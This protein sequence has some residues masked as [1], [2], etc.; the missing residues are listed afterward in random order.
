MPAA[1]PAAENSFARSGSQ[2]DNEHKPKIKNCKEAKDPE[3]EESSPKGTQVM[4]VI[5]ED[6]DGPHIPAGQIT[7]SIVSRHKK[8]TIDKKTGWLSTNAMFNRDEPEREK[9]V[10]VT[11]KA[12]DN[13]RPQLEDVCTLKVN[14]KDIN[15]NSP[16][17]DRSNYNVPVA[18]DTQVGTTIMQISA[19]DVDEGVNQQINYELEAL[20]VKSDIDYFQYNHETGV[21]QLKQRIDKPTGHNFLLLATA[22]DG[23]NPR[24]SSEIKITLEVTESNNKLPTF[25]DGPGSIR[26]KEGYNDYSTPIAEYV[27]KSNVD[28]DDRVF[29]QLVNGRTEKT[30]KDQTFR[31]VQSTR[32]PSTVAIYL[33]K[34]L[35][36]EKVNEYMLTLQVRNTPDLVAEAQLRIM[37]EDENNLAPIFINVESGSV[38]EN[39]SEGTIVM[40]VSADDKDGTYPNNKVTYSIS[41][42]NPKDI[43]DKFTINSDTGVVRTKQMFDR[44][45]QAVYAVTIDAEDGAPSSLLKNGQPNKTPNNFRIVIA[46]KNDNPPYF[47]QQQYRADAPEDQDVLSKVIEVTAEDLD[48]EASVTTYQIIDG[49]IGDK[50]MIEEQTGFIRVKQ[51]L[52]YEE[53]KEYNLVV[54]AWDGTYGNR[55]NV[56]ITIL[57][58]NDLKPVFSQKKYQIRQVEETLPPYPI[59]QV[60]AYDP[61]I[62]DR[63]KDQ[64]ITYYLDPGSQLA[65]YFSINKHTGDLRIVKKLDRDKP[66]GYPTREMFIYAKDEGGGPNGIESYVP[67]Q[68]DLMDIN[69]NAPFLNMPDGL[70][71]PEG[72]RP[73]RV[74]QLVADDYDAPE[75]GPPYTFEIDPEKAPQDIKS[76]FDIEKLADGSYVLVAREIFDR[77]KKKQFSIP[78]RI[79]DHEEMC[80]T[81]DL[82]LIIGDINDNPMAPGTSEIFVYNYEG[83]APDTE[84]GRVY[85]Q[86]PDDWDLPDKTFRF[87][88]GWKWEKYFALNTDTGTLH[89]HCN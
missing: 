16:V 10:Y 61:D 29:F 15:D 35:S 11:V 18:Q 23:G 89:I 43:R 73:G 57:N 17:F 56:K 46:D 64:N 12:T 62:G 65:P 41:K 51:P 1:A 33:A 30:N 71:W 74:G 36:Y 37:L 21:V 4:Q 48:K 25:V 63:S 22:S 27:A 19:T 24:R 79:C 84:I 83:L 20:S 13:G 78:V 7:Y 88:E 75:N 82:K 9:T 85:V 87:E 81:S 2:E 47:P 55:T 42:N 28:G 59:M 69:D 68:I 39:E 26:L 52:D 45:E 6:L 50:F 76:W 60:T 34:P 14:I 54:S 3:V 77:E 66:Y 49:N 40:Q 8:F 70:V 31:A 53:R 67:F 32:D 80:A 58:V 44:E 72:A 38:L 5:A 86:D